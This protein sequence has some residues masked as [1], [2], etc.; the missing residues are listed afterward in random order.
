[1]GADAGE[2]WSSRRSDHALDRL[3]CMHCD[4][5]ACDDAGERPDHL[6]IEQQMLFRKE[7]QKLTPPQRSAMLAGQVALCGCVVCALLCVRRCRSPAAVVALHLSLQL[8][9]Q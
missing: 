8:Q 4:M 9:L 3:T 7:W 5:R 6:R 1:M 2:G